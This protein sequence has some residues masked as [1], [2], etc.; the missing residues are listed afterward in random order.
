M[1]AYELDRGFVPSFEKN[2][3]VAKETDLVWLNVREAPFS[4]HGVFYDEAQGQ[5]VRMD[6]KVVDKVNTDVKWLN[7][8]T[9]GGRVCFKTDSKYI[10]FHAVM[11]DDGGHHCTHSFDQAFDIL[12]LND[13]LPYIT[14]DYTFTPPRSFE[15]NVYTAGIGTDGVME[16]RV[17]C[18]PLFNTVYEL[19]IAVKRDAEIGFSN[20]YVYEKPV[21]F[22][23]SSITQGGCASRP[24]NTYQSILSKKLRFDYTTLGFAGNAKGEIEIAEYIADLDMSVFVLDYDHNAPDAEHLRK[25]HLPFFRAVREKNPTLPIVI[26]SAPNTMPWYDWY[27]SRRD[28]IRETYETAVAEGDKNVYFIDGSELFGEEDRDLCTLD[29]CHPNDLGMYRMACRI[30]PVLKKILR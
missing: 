27:Q 20:P 5:F 3:E 10:A 29:T 30:E 14:Y 7:R 28:A 24:S 25:T 22:Y 17:L 4:L 1:K 6:Q 21:V 12:R 18:L 9:A 15:G 2:C 23:G 13:T 16:D 26:I 8:Q 11:Y 19:Y